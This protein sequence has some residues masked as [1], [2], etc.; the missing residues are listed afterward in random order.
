MGVTRILG[1]TFTDCAIGVRHKYSSGTYAQGNVRKGTGR[2]FLV[3]GDVS[4]WTDGG[5]NVA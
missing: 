5:G 2:L 3:D 4:A 1:N